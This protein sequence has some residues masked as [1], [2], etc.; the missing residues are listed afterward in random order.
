[1]DPYLEEAT[2]AV[3]G[4]VEI[5]TLVEELLALAQD[6]EAAAQA[7][8]SAANDAVESIRRQAEDTVR[9][10]AEEEI[11]ERLPLPGF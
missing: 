10:R 2:R 7:A 4:V 9:E 1:V 8:R 3:S 6:R 5:E 11:R